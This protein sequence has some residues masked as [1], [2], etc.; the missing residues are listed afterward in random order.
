KL[1]LR[2]ALVGIQKETVLRTIKI[3]I[4]ISWEEFLADIT[5]CQSVNVAVMVKTLQQVLLAYSTSLES[6]SQIFESPG[7]NGLS[8]YDQSIPDNGP[9]TKFATTWLDLQG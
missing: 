8:L 4:R 3:K 7:R 1:E 6:S 2:R 9:L 5:T